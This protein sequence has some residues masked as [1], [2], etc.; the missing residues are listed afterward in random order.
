MQDSLSYIILALIGVVIYLLITQRKKK[1]EPVDN[2][3]ELNNLKESINNSFNT[4]SASFNNLWL[5]NRQIRNE[6]LHLRNADDF[7]V[8]MIKSKLVNCF[9]I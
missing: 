3:Q 6:D 4:M 1:E 5:Y 7:Y 8:P 9:L 2:T